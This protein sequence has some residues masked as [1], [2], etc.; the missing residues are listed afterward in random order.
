MPSIG[1][2]YP[3]ILSTDYVEIIS[4]LGTTEAQKSNLDFLHNTFLYWDR[5]STVVKLLY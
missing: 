1:I 5:D 2:L 3:I 4:I